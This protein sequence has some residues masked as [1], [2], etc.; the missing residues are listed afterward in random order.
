MHWIG[1]ALFSVI[2]RQER[3]FFLKKIQAG[4]V[5]T[6][7]SHKKIFHNFLPAAAT[8]LFLFL[9]LELFSSA[10]LIR[11]F[12]IPAPSAVIRSLIQNYGEMLP[13][14]L[15]T[16]WVCLFGFIASIMLSFFA[17]V[18]MDQIPAVKSALY[19]LVIAS[20]TIPIMVITPV[21]VLLVGFGLLPKILVVILVCFFPICINLYDGF[22]GVD[23]DMLMLMRSM[24]ATRFQIFRH[25]K[26]P[27]G[28]PS[29]FSGIRISA[30]YCIMATVIAEWQGSDRGLG[31]YLMRVKRSYSYEKMFASILVIVGLSLLFFLVALLAEKRLIRW[32]RI[33]EKTS[34][35]KNI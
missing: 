15:E 8:I 18:V 32:K 14:F 23:P 6:S 1:S 17:A 31:V 5:N 26:L 25:V 13:H 4:F 33:A 30:T 3:G 27:S 9:A 7:S 16:L 22:T 21:I 34:G 29:M 2:T 24:N 10:G 19:P 35:S 20:Q 28:L 12:I 11:N